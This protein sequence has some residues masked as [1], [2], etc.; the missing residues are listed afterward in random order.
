M[1]VHRRRD[2][3]PVDITKTGEGTASL[4]V[5]DETVDVPVIF[6]KTSREDEL[7]ILA[8]PA[9]PLV[10]RLREAGAEL[11]RTIEGVLPPLKG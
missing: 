9:S 6:C 8:D 3:D 7:T 2:A 4:R 1:I 10:L 11:E 5:G